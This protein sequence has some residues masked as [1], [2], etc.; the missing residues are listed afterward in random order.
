MINLVPPSICAKNITVEI[1]SSELQIDITSP[2]WVSYSYN[3]V[4]D[5]GGDPGVQRN[6]PLGWN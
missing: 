4:A 6:P 5:L 1:C 2:N 3:T